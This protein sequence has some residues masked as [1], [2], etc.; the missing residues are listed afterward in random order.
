MHKDESQSQCSPRALSAFHDTRCY[1]M[2]EHEK[3]VED[4]MQKLNEHGQRLEQIN[5]GSSAALVTAKALGSS[6]L[7]LHPSLV[8]AQYSYASVRRMSVVARRSC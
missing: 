1:Q 4:Q 6:A 8:H 2:L 7:F 5:S 3:H